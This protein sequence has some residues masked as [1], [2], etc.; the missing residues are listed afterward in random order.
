MVIYLVYLPSIDPINCMVYLP[1]IFTCI[2]LIFMVDVSEYTSPMDP[3]GLSTCTF[4][5]TSSGD[6]KPTASQQPNV[7]FIW[8]LKVRK[9][10]QILL[11]RLGTNVICV[12]LEQ[13]LKL[14]MV[15]PPLNRGILNYGIYKYTKALL[16]KRW[17]SH[18]TPRH[19]DP[20]WNRLADVRE[21]TCGLLVSKKCNVVSFNIP[22][23]KLTVCP[24][25]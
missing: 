8:L 11:S 25:K 19:D 1:S 24:W 15:I 2:Q 3:M 18:N 22:F 20:P 23:L 4:V 5:N 16:G 12:R 6:L 9:S 14:G 7:G 21:Q 10:L 13:L 17:P